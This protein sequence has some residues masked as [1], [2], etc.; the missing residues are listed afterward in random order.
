MLQASGGELPVPAVA[1][2]VGLGE[3]QLHRLFLQRVG[4][5]PKMFARVT[6]LQRVAGALV[7]GGVTSPAQL[8]VAHG[9]TDQPHMI[10]DFQALAGVTPAVYAR[11]G[12]VSEIDNRD[13]NHR[14]IVAA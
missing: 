10:R 11:R 6:R 14:A 12:P 4:Y 2:R 5:G 3:R 13:G 1:T 9:Y 8:A 7:R